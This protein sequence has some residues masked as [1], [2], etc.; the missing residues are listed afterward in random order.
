MRQGCFVQVPS[1]SGIIQGSYQKEGS[2]ALRIVCPE[3]RVGCQCYL[4]VQIF[5]AKAIEIADPNPLFLLYA[6]SHDAY[7]M[8][9]CVYL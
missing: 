5:Q 2:K 6:R 3:Q 1:V 9:K 7:G 4:R 8:L